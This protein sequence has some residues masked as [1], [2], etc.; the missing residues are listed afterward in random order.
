[1][2]TSTNIRRRMGFVISVFL[3]TVSLDTT[4]NLQAQKRKNKPP[5][6]SAALLWRDPG[7]IATRDL[8]YGPGSP[9]LA[10]APPFRF[11]KEDKVG[12]SPKFDVE[13]ARGMKWKVKLGEEA[14]AETVATR[15]VWA[16]GYFAEEAYYFDRVR[17]S[18]LPRLSRGRKY[19]QGTDTV[20]RA[21]FEPRRK[22]VERGPSWD[23]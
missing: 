7:D 22:G 2:C 21:R 11:L 16:A 8:R 9:E 13:D 20:R 5:K 15:L 3:I 23:W 19:V 4:S 6:A 1:M 12:V 18:N 10:P 14:Q 17:I